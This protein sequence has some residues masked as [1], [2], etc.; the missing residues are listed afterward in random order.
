M[1]YQL[2][3]N[4]SLQ[5]L[6]SWIF[7]AERRGGGI[8]INGSVS[9]LPISPSVCPSEHP[10]FSNYTYPS[11]HGHGPNTTFEVHFVEKSTMG[12]LLHHSLCGICT[13]LLTHCCNVN[14]LAHPSQL[15]A[16]LTSLLRVYVFLECST[17]L[18]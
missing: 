1:L 7:L 8:F 10:K 13:T 12:T 6:S 16:P 15:T 11:T 18:L 2:E 4:N 9:H 5:D 3:K 14:A 17:S